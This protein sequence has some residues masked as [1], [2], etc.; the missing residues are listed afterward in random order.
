[1]KIETIDLVVISAVWFISGLV[2][3]Y[4]FYPAWVV[5][6]RLKSFAEGFDAGWESCKRH[7]KIG[8]AQ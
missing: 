1:M 7:Y 3:A 4:F 8:G 2:V 6:E 5:K